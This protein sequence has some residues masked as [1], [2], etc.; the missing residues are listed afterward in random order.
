MNVFARRIL[1]S[2]TVNSK[3]NSCSPLSMGESERIL[4]DCAS[5]A[6][7]RYPLGWR[8]GRT[9][10]RMAHRIVDRTRSKWPVDSIDHRGAVPWPV[11]SLDR[12]NG[13]AERGWVRPIDTQNWAK[14]IHSQA[15]VRA[16]GACSMGAGGDWRWCCD[17]SNVDYFSC[18][19]PTGPWWWYRW[20]LWSDHRRPVHW[21]YPPHSCT[22]WAQYHRI[23]SWPST[24]H[25]WNRVF[26]ILHLCAMVNPFPGSQGSNCGEP[27]HVWWY[28]IHIQ[29]EQI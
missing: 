22:G 21:L 4:P 15:W 13:R 3:C 10:G 2:W 6:T 16:V 25:H 29:S 24:T 20:S 23:D 28:S 27:E 1:T 26:H 19:W 9:T 12:S 7:P 14:V 8:W 5:W 18:C 11:H 17:V